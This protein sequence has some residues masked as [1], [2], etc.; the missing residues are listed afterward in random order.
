MKW[1]LW[2]G[3]ET[4]KR[5]WP[6]LGNYKI[7]EEAQVFLHDLD[8]FV[9]VQLL[10]ETPAILSLS[11]LGSDHG[12]SYEWKNGETPW[13][14]R[15]GKTI[16]CTMDNFVPLVVPGLSSSCSSTS[17]STSRPKDQILLMNRKHHQIQWRLE[18]TSEHA[19][20]REP[21]FFFDETDK[22]DPTQGI[23]DCLQP[24]NR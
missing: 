4:L 10:D 22:E 18:V 21:D 19:G 13:L 12:Y 8:L 9:T 14:T 20:N 7:N 23:P 3:P 15:N 17:A 6:R 24:F 16:T 2:G 11:M 1:I 5:Y